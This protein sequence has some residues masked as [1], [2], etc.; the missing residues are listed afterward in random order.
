MVAEFVKRFSYRFVLPFCL[1]G[2]ALLR[3]S[4]VSIIYVV[5]ALIGPAF[6]S[7]RKNIPTS[8]FTR[9]YLL[10]CVAVSLLLTILQFGYQLFEYFTVN[11]KTYEQECLDAGGDLNYW[12]RQTGFIR[13]P[14]SVGL[15]GF[16]II[17]PEIAALIGSITT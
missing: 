3:P 16:R 9:A 6:P 2:G 8:P 4:F 14:E 7:I 17:A 13:V 12:L 11:D 15:V 10:V 1:F 5:L